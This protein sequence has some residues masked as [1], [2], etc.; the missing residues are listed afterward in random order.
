MATSTALEL[1]IATITERL[2]RLPSD[3][4][5]VAEYLL[6]LGYTGRRNSA[7]HRCPL[8]RYLSD[9]LAGVAV[10]VDDLDDQ[11]SVLD[12]D[13]TG[14]LV[15]IEPLLPGLTTFIRRF[16]DGEYP[17]LLEVDDRA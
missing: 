16:D 15:H 17:D 3:P 14:R 11:I 4:D 6:A 5:H 8:A 12:G 13:L 2:D 1:A 10:R 7:A 9:N